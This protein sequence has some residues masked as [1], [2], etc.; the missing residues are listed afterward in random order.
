MK[1]LFYVACHPTTIFSSTQAQ[2]CD[3]GLRAS[4]SRLKCEILA[5]WDRQDVL[6]EELCPFSFREAGLLD[7]GQWAFNTL[8][9]LVEPC[10]ERTE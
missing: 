8:V 5:S 9:N 3:L 4:Q 10:Q 6:N 7:S 2:C 1:G